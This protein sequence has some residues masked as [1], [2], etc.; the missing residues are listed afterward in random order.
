MNDWM[1]SGSLSMIIQ[2]ST[3]WICFMRIVYMILRVMYLL[4]WNLC[5]NDLARFPA[6][7]G[8]K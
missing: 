2:L 4:I 6:I 1:W 5:V 8:G 3:G 7:V